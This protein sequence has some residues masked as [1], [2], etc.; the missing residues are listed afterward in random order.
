LSRPWTSGIPPCPAA[1]G[2]ARRT[3][4]FLN[5]KVAGSIIVVVATNAP[6]LP[7]QL[8]RIAAVSV[9]DLGGLGSF[10]GQFIR[11]TCFLRFRPANAA[12]QSPEGTAIADDASQLSELIRC[13]ERRSKQLKKL[14]LMRCSRRRR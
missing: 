3:V 2:G 6:L 4:A 14:S 10:R 13:F 12:P 5:T 11:V 1:G 7:H 8:E 9:W